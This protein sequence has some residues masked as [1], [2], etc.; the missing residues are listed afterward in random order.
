LL[1]VRLSGRIKGG[2][3]ANG[4]RRCGGWQRYRLGGNNEG[5]GFF[6]R[7]GSRFVMTRVEIDHRGELAFAALSQQRT[8]K[9]QYRK[10]AAGE[11]LSGRV[12]HGKRSMSAGSVT[13]RGKTGTP[14]GVSSSNRSYDL[15]NSGNR[16]KPDDDLVQQD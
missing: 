1:R 15:Y 16:D 2:S 5:L 3:G 14:V 10:Q 13:R 12:R 8:G 7:T 11:L 4:G 6:E 9:C